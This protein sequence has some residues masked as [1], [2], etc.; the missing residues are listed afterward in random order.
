MKLLFAI[1]V[2]TLNLNKRILYALYRVCDAGVAQFI[3]FISTIVFT[4]GERII[5]KY[6]PRKCKAQLEK[7]LA[8]PPLDIHTLTSALS[9]R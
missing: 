9:F 1:K 4:S 7:P 6:Y 3:D 8:Q 5:E 2:Y